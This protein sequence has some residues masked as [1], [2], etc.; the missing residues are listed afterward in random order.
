MKLFVSDLDGTLLNSDHRITEKNKE[1]LR[2]LSENG[3]EIALCSGRV[4]SSVEFIAKEVGV[5]AYA[6][7]NNAAVISYKGDIIY[8]KPINKDTLQKLIDYAL[9]H[10]IKFHMYDKDTFYSNVYDLKRLEHL[11]DDNGNVVQVKTY[12]DENIAEYVKKH[13]ISIFKIMYY[14]NFA[15]DA[16]T[17][18]AIKE[19]EDIYPSM[20]GTTSAD[21]VNVE[22][23]KWHGIEFITKHFGKVYEKIVSIGDYENDIP[24]IKNSDIGI[25]MGNA[26]D[27]VKES[28][29]F[30]TDTND[31]DGFY[32]A[33]INL[34]EGEND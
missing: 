33:V 32:K 24:M 26:L 13:D 16:K 6:L 19:F 18:D 2:L 22:V 4:L 30:I 17:L 5:N 8:Q 9:E 28:A 15:A 1:A 34:L 14:T 31:N 29:D 27:S 10:D 20:S 3:Y 7:G 12:F 11:M 23:N 25:A 21:M